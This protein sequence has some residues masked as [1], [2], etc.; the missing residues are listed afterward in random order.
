MMPSLCPK[1]F[2]RLHKMFSGMT[3]VC[4][5]VQTWTIRKWGG[6]VILV[7]PT[8]SGSKDALCGCRYSREQTWNQQLLN[9]FCMAGTLKG[10][11][12]L[13]A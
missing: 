12:Y 13:L 3:V 4:D 7:G 6:V 9:T 2:Y 10:F 1:P 8:A 11:L 5:M